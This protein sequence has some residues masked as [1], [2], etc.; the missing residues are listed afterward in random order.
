M[1]EKYVKSDIDTLLNELHDS[2]VARY[3]GFSLVNTDKHGFDGKLSDG[4]D[5]FLE[6]KVA[7]FDASSCRQ[8]LT[9][10]HMKRLMH[11]EM[12]EFG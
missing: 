9:T 11:F 4:E 1:Q 12:R 7:G 6:S 3:L 8:L 2:M 5:I 10:R